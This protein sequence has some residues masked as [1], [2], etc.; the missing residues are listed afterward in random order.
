MEQGFAPSLSNFKVCTVYHSM[1][2][3]QAKS[4]ITELLVCYMKFTVLPSF[5]VLPNSNNQGLLSPCSHFSPRWLQLPLN[6]YFSSIYPPCAGRFRVLKCKHKLALLLLEIYE[7]F[8]NSFKVFSMIPKN[9][10]C[11]ANTNCSVSSFISLLTI[12]N[13]TLTAHRTTCPLNV[14]GK[15]NCTKETKQN[16][17]QTTT[18]NQKYTAKG[19]KIPECKN[20]RKASSNDLSYL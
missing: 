15:W 13:I 3:T 1:S 5:S 11:V 16:K 12:I 20:W 6:R 4:M 18:N 8:R 14:L 2:Y 7:H 17:K 9:F 19:H 10:H